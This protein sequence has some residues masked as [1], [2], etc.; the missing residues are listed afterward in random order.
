M[1]LRSSA[2]LFLAS[3]LLFLH[4]TAAC[5]G[6][7]DDD[8]LLI[9]STLHLLIFSS[10]S[11][12]YYSAIVTVHEPW[13]TPY[14]FV[15]RYSTIEMHCTE[16]SGHDFLNVWSVDLGNDTLGIQYRGGD[17]QLKDHGIYELPSLNSSVG[18]PS[19][20]RLLINDTNV[21]NE[22]QIFCNMHST[23]L[24]VYGKQ[25]IVQ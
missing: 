19:V 7:P 15:P 1:S 10:L 6:K 21:N 18:M 23:T 11:T 3:S 9:S 12:Y 17:R 4:L 2:G 14:V 20:L 25:F 22:T 13:P 5:Y 16:N 24:F 8:R